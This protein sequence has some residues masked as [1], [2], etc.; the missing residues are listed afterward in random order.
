MSLGRFLEVFRVEMAFNVKRPLFWVLVVILGFF[1]W[2]MPGGNATISSGNSAVGGTKAWITS[3]F[4]NAQLLAM[5]VSILYAFFVSVGAGM[6]VIRDEELKVGEVLHATPLTPRE[7]MWGKF[8][9]QVVTVLGVLA[10]HLA[11][12]AAFNHGIPR[13]GSEIIGPFVPS[14]YLRPALIFGV[15][16]LLFFA[17]A[18]FAL[19]SW[20]RLPILVFVAPVAV[21]LFCAL[22]LWNWAP[23]WL[24]PNV[25]RLLNLLDPAGLRWLSETWLK[26]DRGVDF[27]NK[28]HVGLDPA[29]I[30]SRVAMAVTGLACVALAERHFARQRAGA[31]LRARDRRA[32]AV[33]HTD[34]E[35]RPP[36]AHAPVGALRMRSGAPGLIAGALE[37]ARV[38]IHELRSTP[39]LY[40]FVPI[41]LLQILGGTLVGVGFFDTPLLNTP[42]TLAG[43]L[44]NTLTVCLALLLLFYTA[45]SLERERR[46][47]LGSLTYA[48]PLRTTSL[49]LGKALANTVVA[50]VVI[51]ASLLGCAIILLIQGKV[52]FDAKPFVLVWG[53]LLLITLVLWTGFVSLV[54]SVTRDRL[55]LIDGKAV[56]MV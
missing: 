47:G 13:P 46:T 23:A 11:T 2:M 19:G 33:E 16:T 32:M 37:V 7:Y 17:G 53:V 8:T 27:Y 15:P 55:R 45:E 6:S 31:K 10:L 49:L 48:A 38:E 29:F 3:E 5:L 41:I 1:A 9:A 39:G 56:R 26:V 44:L 52:P 43:S 42:G 28:G 54:F 20:T 18:A 12:M 30:V 35:V 40:L 14:N 34:L 24:D 51:L 36:V 22:F 25:S 21:V 4:A 50:A